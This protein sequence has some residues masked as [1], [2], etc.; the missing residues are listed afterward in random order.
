MKHLYVTGDTNDAD[1]VS[2]LMDIDDQ[3]LERFMP[4][5]QSIKNF[6]PYI[7]KSD[8]GLSFTHRHNFPKGEYFPRADR[9]EKSIYELYSDIDPEV[10]EEFNDD[11]VP[12]DIHSIESIDLLEIP[13]RKSLL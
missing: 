4:L 13:F 10:L 2:R 3:T 12:Y 9:G 11:Y 7:S 1:Y 8:S 6:K 5:I